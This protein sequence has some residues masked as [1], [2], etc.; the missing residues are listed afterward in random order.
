LHEQE[1]IAKQAAKARAE[2][3]AKKK[4]EEVPEMTAAEMLK[5]LAPD[6]VKD[7]WRRRGKGKGGETPAETWARENKKVRTGQT[8][9]G[10]GCIELDAYLLSHQYS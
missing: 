2:A 4:A 9:V 1:H 10:L 3:E 7:T 6:P 5:R 8:E